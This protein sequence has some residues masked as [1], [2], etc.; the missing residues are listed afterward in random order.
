MPRLDFS[1]VHS[2]ALTPEGISVPVTLKSG[3][4]SIGVLSYVDT[5]A[6]YCLFQR[7][8]GR[9]LN[10]DIEAGE[11][12][13]FQTA[14]SQVNTFGHMVSLEAL[15]ITFESMVYFFADDGIQKNLLGRTGWLDRIRF[16]LVDYDRKFY[17][18]PYDFESSDPANTIV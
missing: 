10:L 12:M 15:G 9:M 5:G 8:H 13:I 7:G 2:Y 1:H 17:I 14:T 4:E 18:A 16:G 11:P 6:S 3:S